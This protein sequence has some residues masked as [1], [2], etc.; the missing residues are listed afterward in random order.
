MT[1]TRLLLLV[2]RCALHV[3]FCMLHVLACLHFGI[4]QVT[5]LRVHLAWHML[6]V[7]FRM[8][9]CIPLHLD[10]CPR[11][12]ATSHVASCAR[13]VSDEKLQLQRTLTA[14]QASSLC[15]CC[16]RMWS[17]ERA[18]SG[19]C[20]CLCVCVCVYMCVW[21]C[22]CA[23]ACARVSACLCA[24]VSACASQTYCTVG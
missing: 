17:C 23:R 12:I 8:A 6:Q 7:A 22:V 15:M 21:L 18:R 5:S 10:G 1:L 3:D 20:A 16:A 4:L 13:Q 14:L 11:C 24:C 2:A 9:C 19:A